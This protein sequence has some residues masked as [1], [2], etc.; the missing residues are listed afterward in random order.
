[1]TT[2]QYPKQEDVFAAIR[3]L[4]FDPQRGM[5]NDEV[6]G[7]L[8]EFNLVDFPLV[9]SV[10]E[11]EAMPPNSLLL[12]NTLK[13]VTNNPERPGASHAELFANHSPLRV[14]YVI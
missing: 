11:L 9:E 13:L 1:M 6:I 3:T 5:G 7:R 14:V 4:P 2:K 8:I 12:T 10:E